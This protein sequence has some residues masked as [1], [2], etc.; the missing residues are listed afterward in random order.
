MYSLCMCLK[1]ENPIYPLI[2]KADRFNSRQQ[3]K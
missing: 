3:K 2:K 1:T